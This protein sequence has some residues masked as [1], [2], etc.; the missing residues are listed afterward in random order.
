MGRLAQRD[1]RNLLNCLRDVY[2]IRSLSAFRADVISTLRN[3]VPA[4]H[5][6][7]N[8]IDPAR[9]LLITLT[10]PANAVDFPNSLEVFRRHISEHPLIAYYARTRAGQALKI[11]DFLTQR[12]FHRLG[13]YNEFFRRVDVEHQM[14]F[15][16]PAPSP[17]MI[18]IALNRSR[19]DFTERERFC[20]DLLRPHLIQAYDIA[21]VIG[22]VDPKTALLEHVVNQGGLGVVVLTRGEKV[23]LV[24]RLAEQWLAEYFGGRLAQ[25]KRLPDMLRRWVRCQEVASADRD[26]IPLSRE[27]LRVQQQ[28]KELVVR[29]LC[30]PDQSLLLLKEQFAVQP[31]ALEAFGLTRREA[32]VLAWVAQGKTNDEI[33]IILGVS[34]RTVAKH[35]EKMYPKLGVENRTAA[36]VR[37]LEV[38][39]GR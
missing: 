22:Q 10:N 8:E 39:S 26:H 28:G 15:T 14:A 13:L 27:P 9:K 36:A 37:A 16:L 7:Y 20:L 21:E 34:P 11:S 3:V 32:E 5:T 31:P 2:A 17:V 25:M 23:R 38:L 24:T 12:Q 33:A 19:A 6:S 4:D 30:E 1:L 29:L 35:L 18:G